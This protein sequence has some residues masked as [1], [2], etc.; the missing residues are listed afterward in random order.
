VNPFNI[1]QWVSPDENDAYEDE[2]GRFLNS[3]KEVFGV[4]E[5]VNF[6]DCNGTIYDNFRYDWEVPRS[7]DVSFLLNRGKVML[8]YGQLDL[9]CHVAGWD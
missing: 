5:F 6:D 7:G 3:N 4:P 8:F 2:S 9:I 1:G